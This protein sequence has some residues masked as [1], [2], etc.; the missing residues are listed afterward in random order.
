MIFMS[1]KQFN[2]YLQEFIFSKDERFSTSKVV[3]ENSNSIDKINEQAITSKIKKL[4]L[5]RKNISLILHILE[6]LIQKIF[7][8][9]YLTYI[10]NMKCFLKYW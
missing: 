8:N 5:E 7:Y 6:K 4:L 2:R 9:L 1:Y 3:K 10:L